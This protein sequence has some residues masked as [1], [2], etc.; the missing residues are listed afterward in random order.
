MQYRRSHQ[1]HLS[2]SSCLHLVY[3]FIDCPFARSCW[4]LAELELLT[5]G[6]DGHL[7]R[8]HMLKKVKLML[9]YFCTTQTQMAT[10]E[11]VKLMLYFQPPDLEAL[12]LIAPRSEASYTSILIKL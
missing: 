6:F 3:F 12:F 7:R 1:G 5:V 8:I 11:K 2:V 10:L 4:N 9:N